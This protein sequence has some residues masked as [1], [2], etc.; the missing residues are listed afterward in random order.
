MIE[1]LERLKF[2]RKLR[3]GS[4][5]RWCGKFEGDMS[6]VSYNPWSDL[7]TCKLHGWDG[8]PH[9]LIKKRVEFESMNKRG[10]SDINPATAGV[11]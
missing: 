1:L 2:A 3:R 9:T 11:F 10:W 8:G 4:V 7:V 5:P 6:A